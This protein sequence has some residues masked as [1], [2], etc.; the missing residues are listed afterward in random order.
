MSDCLLGKRKTMKSV[1]MQFQ[2]YLTQYTQMGYIILLMVEFHGNITH[3]IHTFV[4]LIRSFSLSL[5]LFFKL[6]ARFKSVFD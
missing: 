1:C 6:I 4:I 3:T 5:K 2:S